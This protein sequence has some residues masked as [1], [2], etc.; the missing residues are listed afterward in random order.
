M[1]LAFIYIAF[2]AEFASEPAKARESKDDENSH[3]QM[4]NQ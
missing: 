1:S 3:Q 4:A 2:L